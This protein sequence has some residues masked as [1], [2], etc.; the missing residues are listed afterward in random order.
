MMETSFHAVELTS[1]QRVTVRIEGRTIAGEKQTY[2][3]VLEDGR[4]LARGEFWKLFREIDEE[5]DGDGI[6]YPF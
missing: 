3:H 2:Y 4:S 5:K 1:G 6:P